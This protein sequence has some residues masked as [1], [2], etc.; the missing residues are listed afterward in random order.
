MTEPTGSI[1]GAIRL[2]QAGRL[3]EGVPLLEAA[4]LADPGNEDALYNLGMALSD[5]G[6]LVL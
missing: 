6:R 5:L 1:Q 3:A 2:L 4:L